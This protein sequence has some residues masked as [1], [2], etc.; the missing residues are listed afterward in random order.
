MTK[1]SLQALS[2]G[3]AAALIC[4]PLALAQQAPG[5]DDTTHG[6]TS[7]GQA[8]HVAAS[9]KPAAHVAATHSGAA[10]GPAAQPN[11]MSQGQQHSGTAPQHYATPS[12]HTPPPQ[13]Q[14]SSYNSGHQWHQGD[15]YNGS[16]HVVSNWNS[17]HLRQP[18]QGYEWVQDGSQ[19]VLVAV[20]S[21]VIADVIL[22]AM[23][24]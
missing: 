5:H 10:H 2:A 7:H 16:R 17:Y 9:A 4:A 1:I 22:N 19:F 11:H 12:Q 14:R 21:G 20:A 6:Q 23:N 24:Q 3:V 18:P 15:H 8:T 13:Q